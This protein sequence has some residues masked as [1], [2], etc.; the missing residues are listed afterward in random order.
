MVELA[1]SYDDD[2]NDDAQGLTCYLDQKRE[3]IEL[4][5]VTTK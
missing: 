3:W 5:G 4:Q 1:G 2:S